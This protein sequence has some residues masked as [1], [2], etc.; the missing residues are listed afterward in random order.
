ML[1]P[2]D[3]L[4]VVRLGGLRVAARL[5]TL[6][7]L[8]LA[9]IGATAA[10]HGD[11]AGWLTGAAGALIVIAALLAHLAARLAITRRLG[12][13]VRR[14]HLTVFGG[15]LD[16]LDDA[17]TPRAEALLGLAGLATLGCLAVAAGLGDLL[18]REGPERLH[19]TAHA[20]AIVLAGLLVVR[21]LPGL[22]LD[23]GHLLRGLVWYLTDSPLAGGRAAAVYAQLIAFGMIGFGAAAFSFAGPAP[24]WGLWAV[25][26]GWQLGGEAR[27]AALRARWQRLARGV[28]LGDLVAPPLSLP[29]A[30]TI[31][32]AIEP[33]LG[34]GGDAPFLVGGTD[35]RPIGVLRLANLRG[36]PRAEWD[37][38]TVAEVTT[39]LAGLPRLD[40]D[41]PAVDALALF[42]DLERR[43]VTVPGGPVVVIERDGAPLAALDLRGVLRRLVS[44]EL[45]GATTAADGAAER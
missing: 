11:L 41:R 22:P 2:L 18:T 9:G 33:L 3:P 20:V 37:R 21:A 43:P 17:V 14:A 40:A 32:D 38:R 45:A 4:L 31:E 44:A 26:A 34:A 6:L 25:I 28:Q 5:G 36:C 7:V 23:G 13:T 19:E 35:G 30:T 10:D 15:V 39:P 8:G 29:G 42:D 27:A 16:S 24:F 12:S 1:L